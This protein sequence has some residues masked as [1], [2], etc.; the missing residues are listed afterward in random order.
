MR[1]DEGKLACRALVLIIDVV[2]VAEQAMDSVQDALHGLPGPV[3]SLPEPGPQLSRG[4]PRAHAPQRLG[5]IGLR[6]HSSFGHVNLP[7]L[8]LFHLIFQTQQARALAGCRTDIINRLLAAAR[9]EPLAAFHP[10]VEIPEARGVPVLAIGRDH[11]VAGALRHAATIRRGEVLGVKLPPVVHIETASAPPVL[12]P[13]HTARGAFALP[14]VEGQAEPKA[15]AP[16]PRSG[17]RL[18]AI[19]VCDA[20]A[21]QQ[22][23]AAGAADVCHVWAHT[24]RAH[25][26]RVVAHLELKRGVDA[27][28]VR[29]ADAHL[30][31]SDVLRQAVQGVAI[32]LFHWRRVWLPNGVVVN[33]EWPGLRPVLDLASV[34]HRSLEGHVLVARV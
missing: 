11:L 9:L 22:A 17:D 32:K 29:H 5:D 26:M 7:L 16:Q 2:D 25:R 18:V 8:L 27:K 13:H 21:L 20:S 1:P 4:L 15:S 10:A 23:G 24:R 12:A 19:R 34:G 6:L 30:V 3:S 14:A 31:H 33:L 28:E